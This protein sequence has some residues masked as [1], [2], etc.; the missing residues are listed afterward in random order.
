MNETIDKRALEDLLHRVAQQ[1]VEAFRALYDQTSGGLLGVTLRIC[2]DRQMAEDVLQ[3]VYVQIWQRA[4]SFDP[5]RAPGKAWITVIA[6][7]R[8]IDHIRRNGRPGSAGRSKEEFEIE[9]LP[10]LAAGV[11][12]DSDLRALARCLQGLPEQHRA[13]ILRAY[14]H[15]WERDEIASHFNIPVNTIKTWLRRGLIAL[16]HCM[17]GGAA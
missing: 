3:E 10:S 12:L 15:G 6:R 14:Y 16:R 4:G 8:A 9:K 1:D 5:A 13:A 2:R 11:E 7:N 17:D